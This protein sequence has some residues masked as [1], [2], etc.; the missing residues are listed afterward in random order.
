MSSYGWPVEDVT[1]RLYDQLEPLTGA[2]ARLGWPLLAFIDAIGLMFQDTADLVQDGP[3]GEPGWSIVLDINRVPDVGLSWLAQFIGMHFYTGITTD[4]MR[5]QIRQHV[6]WGRGTPA[7][8]ISAVRLFLT[9]TQTVILAERDS[10]PYHFTVTIW[11]AEAPAD[12][13]PTSALV[14]Y[15]NKFAKPAGLA[16]TLVVNPGTPPALTYDQIYTTNGWTYLNIYNQF[17]TYADIH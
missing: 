4:Q 7:S 9:G 13:S 11:A 16:W 17:Q 6:T 14:S 2:E 10:T 12:T 1:E 8:I 5:Q 3:N 15:V